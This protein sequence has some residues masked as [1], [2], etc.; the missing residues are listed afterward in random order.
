MSIFAAFVLFFQ[1]IWSSI[2]GL[3]S[4]KW[5]VDNQPTDIEAAIPDSPVE[6]KEIVPSMS[7]FI[8]SLV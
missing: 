7:L 8:L 4:S 2:I 5:S 3:F 1:A 6:T